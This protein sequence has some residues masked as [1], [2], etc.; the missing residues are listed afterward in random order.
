MIKKIK[1]RVLRGSPELLSSS[2]VVN[3]ALSGIEPHS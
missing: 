3:G 2:P 1:R